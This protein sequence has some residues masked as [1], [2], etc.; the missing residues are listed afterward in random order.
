MRLS[1]I[2][3]IAL[4]FAAAAV[5]SLVAA[6]FSVQLIEDTSEIG[7]RDALDAQGMTWAEVQA[8]GLQVTLA[9][10]APTEAV[11]FRALST[12][13]TVVDAARVIDEM[14]VEAQ[15]GIAPPR[16]SAEVLRNDAGI[17]IIGLI[18]TSTDREAVIDAFGDMAGDASVTDLLESA[19]YPAPE[20]WEDALSFAV[21]AMA[22]LPR[23]KASVDAGR[24]TITAI[25]DS[26]AAKAQMERKLQ[27]AAPPS[28]R[29]RLDIA[30]P[31]PVITPFTLRFEIA[32]EGAR[33]DACSADTEA[34]A[35]RILKAGITAGASESADCTIG[36][37]V[38]S[39]NWGR[40]VALTIDALRRLGQGSISFADADITLLA[41]PGTESTT[42]DRVV[43]ELE[44]ALPDVFALT[45]KLPEVEDPDAGPP[46]FTATLSPE[47]QVQLRGRL[48]NEG[49]RDLADSY[50]KSHFG[51][52]NVYTAARLDE[53]LPG[54]WATRVLTGL[55]AM[56]SLANG[57]VKVTPDRLEV[58][59]NTGNKDANTTVASLLADKLGEGA[60]YSIDIIYQEKLDPIAGLPTP[61][62][63]EA[64]IR[65]I[66]K[67]GK[68][69]F[70]PGSATIDASALG[71]MDDIAEV[72][73]NCG[74]IR[75]EIQ[76][77]TDSQ[78]RESMNLSL[79]QSRAES[80]L[81][82]LR[83]R[84]VLTSSFVAKGYGEE[85][86]IAD[87]KTEEGREANRRIEFRLIQ[88]EAEPPE[89][90]TALE[91]AEETGD[92]TAEEI[93]ESDETEEGSGDEQN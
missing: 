88:P 47:G 84:R 3:T 25:A 73:K 2:F 33:F 8:D 51:S 62:E 39:P 9:G 18:P 57:S 83:A 68:I 81:N 91:S 30:A 38:P 31:R 34:A 67:I 24:V 29:L 26:A 78:G 53:A 71:T 12:A 61:E 19:D 43:G 6:S 80:V 42:F 44:N 74:D 87:N 58:M 64:E 69:T 65:E 52:G 4:T 45:A 46:E 14:E 10:I 23:A 17:S 1:A 41:A 76:G 50:A 90:E 16:F 59:G 5:V 82:E 27:R 48:S 72:L 66:L 79:S 20:G 40:A 36:L 7:V 70:E 77:Y 32:A 21:Q 54:D 13:G 56:A 37:G 85:N 63:C 89:D 86:P 92:T 28:L 75:L 15:S 35:D 93:G 60:D 11:R 55:E 22:D 49:L